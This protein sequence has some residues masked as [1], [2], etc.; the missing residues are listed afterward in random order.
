MRYLLDF[1]GCVGCVG[2]WLD[3]GESIKVQPGRG[4]GMAFLVRFSF[5]LPS[6]LP[7][8]FVGSFR[9]ESISSYRLV[10][11][12]PVVGYCLVVVV[13]LARMVDS[14]RCIWHVHWLAKTY[15]NSRRSS[16]RETYF[17]VSQSVPIPETGQARPGAAK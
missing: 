15:P 4:H 10:Q 5:R 6:F 11:L 17:L 16:K 13:F 1:D 14:V 8:S 3:M 7:S 12:G 2:I 9:S